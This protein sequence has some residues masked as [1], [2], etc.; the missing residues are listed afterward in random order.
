MPSATSA[1]AVTAATVRRTASSSAPR[2]SSQAVAAPGTA[3]TPPGRTSI[4]PTVAKQPSA[5]AAA[6]GQHGFGQRDHRVAAVGHGGG[7]RMVGLA[8]EVET[9]PT[10]RPDAR[11]DRHR[12]TEVHQPAA[13]LDVKLDEAADSAQRL[14][15]VRPAPRSA[16]DL[17]AS[18]ME[19]PSAS[20]R[21][22]P[23]GRQRR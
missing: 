16:G 6:G 18:A 10:V 17:N 12:P 7:A 5:S 20:T 15:I 3:L 11:A 22:G 21:P 8:R 19:M 1:T 4:R 23:V 9:P 14:V 13:L 2:A